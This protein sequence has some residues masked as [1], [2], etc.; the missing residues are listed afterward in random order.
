MTLG[1]HLTS[2]GLCD[3]TQ[4]LLYDNSGLLS[5]V[6]GASKQRRLVG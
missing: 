3:Y 2:K 4:G 6:C 5:S 1:L